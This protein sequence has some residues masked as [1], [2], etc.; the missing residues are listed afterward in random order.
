MPHPAY[1]PMLPP[2]TFLY[3]MLRKSLK[4][5][6]FSSIKGIGS[7]VQSEL[8]HMSKDVFE[9]VFPLGMYKKSIITDKD[10]P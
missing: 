4:G 1:S 9:K 6:I 10:S 5:Q 7:A 2:T 8:Q 3:Q